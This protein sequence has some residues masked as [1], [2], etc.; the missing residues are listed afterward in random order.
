MVKAVLKGVFALFVVSA[1]VGS[2]MFVAVNAQNNNEGQLGKDVASTFRDIVKRHQSDIEDF[3]FETK[4]IVATT[5]EARLALIDLYINDTLRAKIEKVN[6]EREALVA[7]L[8]AGEIDNETFTME[9]KDLA[10]TLADVAKTMGVIGEKLHELGEELAGELKARAEQL[11][12]DL[13]ASA[14]EMASAGKAI[15]DEMR[16]RDLPV[17]DIPEKPD[18]PD[19]PEIP[20]TPEQPEIPEQPETPETPG[21]PHS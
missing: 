2:C 8:Q 4:V 11:V 17:P 20:E 12:A 7:D 13:Q 9:M 16:N 18:I 1:I 10:S 14:D 21:Y 3:I 5:A 19:R 6:L 15:R